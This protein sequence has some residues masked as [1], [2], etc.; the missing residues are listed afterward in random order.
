MNDE[1]LTR[2]RAMDK[3]RPP[4]RAER[5]G[6]GETLLEGSGGSRPR[7]WQGCYLIIK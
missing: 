1:L 3:K 2:R 5:R 6:L 7:K 4:Q